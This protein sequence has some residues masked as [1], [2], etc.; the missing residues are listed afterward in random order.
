MCNDT[1]KVRAHVKEKD[2][3]DFQSFILQ[4]ENAKL[5]LLF[6]FRIRYVLV[7]IRNIS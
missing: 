4:F 7:C 5:L 2:K 1:R 3:S 6:D